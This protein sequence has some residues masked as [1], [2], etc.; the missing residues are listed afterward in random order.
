MVDERKGGGRGKR[1][2]RLRHDRQDFG[3]EKPTTSFVVISLREGHFE[4]TLLGSFQLVLPSHQFQVPLWISIFSREKIHISHLFLGRESPT[5]L[6]CQQWKGWVW[7]RP[8]SPHLTSFHKQGIWSS[9]LFAQSHTPSGP[10]QSLRSPDASARV[11]S[12]IWADSRNRGAEVW[13]SSDSSP[14]ILDW[15]KVLTV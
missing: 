14:P 1:E 7:P 11:Y 4:G 9:E 5:F 6:N 2:R 13:T 10:R 12:T 8:N 15:Q 3:E